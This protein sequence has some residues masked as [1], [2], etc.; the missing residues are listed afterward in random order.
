MNLLYQKMG[1]TNKLRKSV[2]TFDLKYVI[3]HNLIYKS[4]HIVEKALL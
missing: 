2:P 4:F 1:T 3:I